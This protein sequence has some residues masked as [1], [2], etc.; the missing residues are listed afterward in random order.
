MRA[1]VVRLVLVTLLGVQVAGAVDLWAI[2][3]QTPHRQTVPTRT[4]TSLVPP[5]P[6]LS[7]SPSLPQPSPPPRPISPSPQP[8]PSFTPTP[9]QPEPSATPLP[10]TG[11]PGSS[12]PQA[13]PMT[14][15][16]TTASATVFPTAL[17]T[18]TPTPTV[19][20]AVEIPPSTPVVLLSP[21]FPSL[22]TGTPPVHTPVPAAGT[23]LT[24]V[25]VSPLFGLGV[26]LIALGF[27][28]LTISRRG[29][30]KEIE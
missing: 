4:P 20:A 26:A 18:A 24:A 10:E 23:R 21:T 7:P 25:G 8:V 30:G 2:P 29:S 9:L 6:T 19:K 28:F 17:L 12:Q 15:A 1:T 27:L 14:T 3:G 16:T 11:M 13:S 22:L 5:L